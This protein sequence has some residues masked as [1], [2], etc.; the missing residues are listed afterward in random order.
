[1]SDTRINLQNTP[2]PADVTS[3]EVTFTSQGCRL[4]GLLFKPAA[5]SG[6]LPGVIV[7]G[8]WTTVKEQMPGT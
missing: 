3:E 7:T 5:A 4:N 2:T 8:A 1:M 6:A